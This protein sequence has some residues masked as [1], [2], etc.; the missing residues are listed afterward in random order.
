M[1]DF[2]ISTEI[3]ASADHVWSILADVR[4]WP[5]WTAS[6]SEIYPLKVAPLGVGS[7]V[8]VLQPRL[9]PAIMTITE[10]EPG[11]G[12][13]WVAR[14]PGLTAIAAHHLASTSSGCAVTLSVSYRGLLSPVVSIFAA[15][16]TRHYIELEATGL[17]ARSEGRR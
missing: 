1:R 15:R 11:C 3:N 4:R 17:K 8:R 9:R 10:W 13:T 6:I 2:Q 14:N 16:L 5:E 12:F 7:Q